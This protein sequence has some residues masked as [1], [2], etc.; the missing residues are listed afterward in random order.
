M[1][2]L[3]LPFDILQDIVHLISPYDF[4]A[5]VVSSKFIHATLQPLLEAHNSLRKRYRNF[6]LPKRNNRD[7]DEDKSV[8][9]Y[10]IPQLL[11]EI[12]TKPRIA[13]Y[14]VHMDLEHREDLESIIEDSC[15]A[16]AVCHSIDVARHSLLQL[17]KQSPYLRH[18][19]TTP[20]QILACLDCIT[21]ERVEVRE[22]HYR[23]FC[24]AFLLS[25]L[26]NI[27]SLA[28]SGY[29]VLNTVTE[30]PHVYYTNY[31]D[32]DER[33]QDLRTDALIQDL[34]KL[35]VDRANDEGLHGQPL[36][37]L[38][39]LY[40]TRDIDT[41]YGHDMRTIFPL[42]SLKSL[43]KVYHFDGTLELQFCK[44]NEDEEE[45]AKDG[46]NDDDDNQQ[47]DSFGPDKDR[48]AA[49]ECDCESC[50]P[51]DQIG[52][53]PPESIWKR[54]AVLGPNIEH[55]VLDRCIIE[56]EASDKFFRKM[57][58]LKTLNYRHTT[59]EGL[60]REW[61]PDYFVQGIATTIGDSLEKLLILADWVWDDCFAIRSAL[62]SFTKLQH[63]E[64][65]T[66]FL[67]D[68][69]E[70][71]STPALIQ[72]LPKTLQ[73]LTLHMTRVRHECM[74][75]L[76]AGFKDARKDNLPALTHVEVRFGCRDWTEDSDEDYKRSLPKVQSVA[77]ANGLTVVVVRSSY[78]E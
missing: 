4:E 75:R 23:D 58:K 9:P 43:R 51:K 35:L 56:P 74:A 27:E 12:A 14:I 15:W 48:Y 78:D 16:D 59:K 77:D 32:E 38:H 2:L 62:H 46:D 7:K 37:K 41:Q 60:G 70:S 21:K 30:D 66:T 57:T 71:Y 20:K 50:C 13:E 63:L 40:P 29:W 34:V 22:N 45:N 25:L 3:A 5:L 1:G 26:P 24:V 33:D 10:T 69:D 19:Q 28:L 39:T 76:F 11:C 73:T 65:D 49:S 8:Q 47:D 64:I 61:D 31:D 54:Y 53:Y 68:R 44:N 55:M 67:V 42:L 72:I 6:T 17:L 36:S 52:F 18:L